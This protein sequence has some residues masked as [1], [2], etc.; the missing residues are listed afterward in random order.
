L[1]LHDHREARIL[2]FEATI[3]A[4]ENKLLRSGK[5]YSMSE[6]AEIGLKFHGYSGKVSG[7]RH[8]HTAEGESIRELWERQFPK[9]K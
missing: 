4:R 5:K 1:Y 3:V 8:W 6:L 9:K 2:E 7:P